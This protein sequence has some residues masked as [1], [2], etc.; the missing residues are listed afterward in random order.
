MAGRVGTG[1]LFLGLAGASPVAGQSPAGELVG[2]VADTSGAVLP[3]VVLKARQLAN[4]R[5]YQTRTGPQGRFRFPRLPPGDFKIAAE[6]RKFQPSPP[7]SVSLDAGEVIRLDLTLQVKKVEQTLTVTGEPHPLDSSS[8]YTSHLVN[9]VS[10][11]S[12]PVNGR[13]LEQL[14]LLTPGMTPVRV[15]D[16]RSL[17]GFTQQLSG[18]GSRGTSFLLDGLDIQPVLF[19][20]STPGGTS[21]LF[22]GVDSV[23]EFEVLSDAYSARLSTAGPTV[24]IV[25]RRGTRGFHG[26]VFEYVRNENLDARNFFDPEKPDF[27]RHQFGGALG[28]PLPGRG[29]TFFFSYEGLRERLG[30]TLI[31]TVPNGEARDGDLPGQGLEV[32]AAVRPIL[33]R[34][35]LPNGEDFGDGTA[36]Y[37][38][39]QVQPT[40]DHHFNIRGDFDLGEQDVVFA[41]YTFHDSAKL[42]PIELTIRG[43]DSDL[44]SRNHYFTLEETH[45]FSSG[46][47]NSFQI[48]LNRT[49][50]GSRSVTRPDLVVPPLIEGRP[51]F[52]RLNIRGLTSFG[53]ET[54]DLRHQMNQLEV[55]DS[56]RWSTQRHDLQFGFNW[57]HYRSDGSYEF[58]FDGLLIYESLASFLTNQPQR[59]LGAE[60]GS[61][62]RRR[63]RQNLFSLF[64]HDQLRLNSQLTLDLGLRYEWFTV[65]TEASGTISNLRSLFDPAPTVGDPLFENPSFGNLAPRVGLAWNLAGK[66]RTVVR[67][68]AGL[69]YEPILENI[70]GY[71]ARIQPPFVTVRTLIRPPY[72][73]P[74]NGQVRGRPRLDP[75]EFRPA[76]PRVLRYHLSLEHAF[77]DNLTLRLGYVGSRGSHLPRVGDVNTPLPIAM[78]PDGRPFWG[79]SRLPR[80]NPNFDLIRFTSTDANSFY[81]SVQVAL[82]RRWQSGLQFAFSYLF[83]RSV[84]DAS[85]Y[86]RVFTNGLADVPPDY[87]NRKAD[88]G[89]S[90]FHL[91]HHGV[92]HYTWDVPSGWAGNGWARKLLRD[93]RTAGILTVSSGSPFTVNVSFDIANN[94]VREGHRPNLLPGA[95]HNPV[96]GGPDR[97]FDVGAFELQ[98]IGYLGTLGRNTLI[99]PG[100]GS[101]DLMAS[102][103]VS[104]SEKHRLELRLEVFNLLN[105]ANFATPRNSATGGVII[106]NNA[107]G[108]PVGNAAK[109]FATVGASRQLQLGLRWRF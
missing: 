50:Y 22:L 24:S 88:R 72:P 15:K 5:V 83:G 28:G 54:A 58:F 63:Y 105:R 93:W 56:L 69:F 36:A 90:N 41:R 78:D 40:D 8:S 49:G 68:A 4:G 92:L 9:Q 101:F 47:L 74:F 70:F 91:A 99:G 55:S 29:N 59:F 18:S 23:E 64:L 52:G 76:T 73:E 67:T 31:D 48:G 45:Y 19:S 81:N 21:G 20:G 103:E 51:N 66:G 34:Y 104:L 39:Q 26:S 79:A 13:S 37:I 62:A 75:F 38:Y 44:R 12:L 102:R 86:R 17:N 108:A 100:Y 7:K 77:S 80:R 42:S 65:P 6:Y 71:G 89:L 2:T 98:E 25:T 109:I 43:F 27:S 96:L 1:L 10:L 60:P 95:D 53:T 30:R 106:F 11:Q 16:T 87:Y 3:G 14:A 85:G 94:Q 35:P 57:K 33:D 61:D 107:G 97:Y 46:L 84:D 32:A 82:T